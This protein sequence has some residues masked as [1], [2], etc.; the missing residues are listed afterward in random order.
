MQPIFV[1]LALGY[2]GRCSPFFFRQLQGVGRMLPFVISLVWWYRGGTLPDVVLLALRGEECCLFLFRYLQGIGYCGGEC[3]TF[4]FCQ[5]QGFRVCVQGLVF[6]N[7]LSR[8]FLGRW[9]WVCCFL[10]MFCFDF[11]R[12]NSAQISAAGYRACFFVLVCLIRVCAQDFV[13]GNILSSIFLG[14][15]FWVCWFC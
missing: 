11:T 6:G 13:F 5:V 4:L 14:C 1:S 12:G 10:V 8:T 9:F 3:C 7:I 15:W 2:M